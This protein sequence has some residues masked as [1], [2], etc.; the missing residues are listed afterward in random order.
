MPRHGDRAFRFRAPKKIVLRA[1]LIDP[2]FPFETANDLLAA[3]L[4]GWHF[5]AQKY[6]PSCL[7]Q[8]VAVRLCAV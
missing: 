6:A 8:G 1:T 3:C 5:R 7:G 4:D 2:A